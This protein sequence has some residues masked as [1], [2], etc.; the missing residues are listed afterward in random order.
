MS[1]KCNRLYIDD[2][3]DPIEQ[4]KIPASKEILQAVPY[5][6]ERLSN[7]DVFYDEEKTIKA[8]EV[9]EDYLGFELIPWELL[10]VALIHCYYKNDDSLVF[11]TFF[12]LVGRGNGKNG[13][14]SGLIFYL[15]THFHGIKGYNVDIIA[16]S[17][18][19]ASVSFD[20]VYEALEENEEILKHYFKW[21]KQVITN[22]ETRSSIKYH[23]SNSKT[24][25]GK[26]SACL[27]FDEVHE[28]ETWNLINVFRSGFGKREHARTFYITTNG[29]VRGG[30]LDEL[31]DLSEKVLSGEIKTLRMLPLIYKIDKE[32]E[33]DN[34]DMWVKANPSL[35]YFPILRQQMEEEYELAKHQPS[36]AS[37]FMTKRMNYPAVENYIEVASWDK[38]MTTNKPIPYDK[39]KGMTCIG[40]FDYAMIND[41]ASCGLL[42]K[43]GGKRYWLEHSF[44]CHLSLK[45][46]SREIKFPIREMADRGLVTIINSDSITPQHIAGW[47]L[48]QLKTYHI[49]DI[50]GDNYR[51]SLVRDE[52]EKHGLPLS[53]VRSGPITHGKIAPIIDDAFAQ[54]TLIFGDNPVMRWYVNNTYR[55]LNDNG[56]TTFLKVEPKTRKTDGFFALIHALARDDAAELL[57]DIPEFEEEIWTPGVYTY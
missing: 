49:L 57:D 1:L 30:I 48:E 45:L 17:Q 55:E 16:N 51:I 54:E 38:I 15:A 37:E 39:L 35:P 22:T 20:D 8:V 21:T 11:T 10:I 53:T 18:D 7:P 9:I 33:R 23:T 19:Q 40:A 41:F 26:R 6:R 43:Y 32:E 29:Y 5:I 24:K 44:V 14:I 56:N 50:A 46:E 47:F 2:Y 36:M 3:L 4:G 12:L 31:L 25:D 27:V 34:P 13:F 28:Y 42:F 52:F